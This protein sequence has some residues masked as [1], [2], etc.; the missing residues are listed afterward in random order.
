MAQIT[1]E[2]LAKILS[3]TQETIMEH[4]ARCARGSVEVNARLFESLLMELQFRRKSAELEARTVT[5][6]LP[7]DRA[8]ESEVSGYDGTEFYR[9]G[10]N[11]RGKA[12]KDALTAQ[13]IKWEAE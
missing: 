8:A 13:G 3:E 10:W 4:N 7:A 12:D 9:A 6:K 5:V 11:A 2:R 1:D